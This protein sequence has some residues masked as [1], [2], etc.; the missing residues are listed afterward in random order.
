MAKEALENALDG[1]LNGDP[2]TLD[3]TFGYG[4]SDECR[5]AITDACKE[6]LE[7]LE[8]RRVMTSA[9]QND[10]NDGACARRTR[11]SSDNLQTPFAKTLLTS[12]RECISR[13]YC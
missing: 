8:K 9:A 1:V 2:S 5:D 7:R 13:S 10:L 3:F 12:T 4:E 11:R 6:G